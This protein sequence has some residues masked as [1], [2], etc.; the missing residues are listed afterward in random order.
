[1]AL[2]LPLMILTACGEPP[3]NDPY[4]AA[5]RGQNIRYSAFSERPKHLDPARSYSSNEVEFIGQI[6]EPPLQY[7]YLKRPYQLIPLT[8]VEVPQPRYYDAQGRRL[9]ADAPAARIA[10]SIYEIRIRP[11][12]HYQPHPAFARDAA[13]R[14]IYDPIPPK[15]LARVDK[16]SDFPVTGTRELTAEDY[17]YQ[18][19][20]LAHPRLNSPIY[21]LMSEYIVGLREFAAE[22][23]RRLKQASP[24]SWLDLRTIPLAGAEVVD[25]YTYRIRIRGKYPQFAYWL[26][27]PFFAPVPWE[28][29]RFYAQPGMQEKNLVLD[30]FPVGTGPYMLTVNDPNRQMVLERNPNFHGETYPTE[31][32]PGDREAGLLRDAGKPLP[33]IDKAVYS[34]EKEDIPYWNK[35]LQGYYDSSGISS[36]TFDQAIRIGATGDAALTEALQRKNIRLVTTVMTTI[37]Y[38]GFNMQDPVVGGLGERARKLRQAI[39]IAVDM[40]ERISIFNNGRGIPA[41]GPIPP[42][43]FGYREGRAG[44]NPYVYDWVNGHAQRKSIAEARRL[45]AEAGYPNG[46]DAQTGRP[47]VLYFDTAAVGADSKSRLEWLVKQFRKLDIELV[48]RATDYN[49]FQDKMLKGTA[50]IF[51]WGWNADYPDPENFLFLLYGPNRKVGANGENAANYENPEFDR[52]FEQ[53]KNMDNGPQRQ[54]IIDQMVEIVRR[55]AP[56]VWGFYPKAFGLYH[57]WL[58]NAKPNLMANNGLKYLRLDPALRERSRREWNQPVLWPVWTGFALLVAGLVPAAVSYWRREHRPPKKG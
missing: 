34:L 44:I 21:G 58:M 51:E 3:W 35:F 27:M 17:V 40:E 57:A 24:E 45:L 47:L 22:L 2:L 41:H 25:R 54:A 13:G 55:D 33:F 23:D 29:D 48:I 38:L 8:A 20:R 7:H 19:K 50:Q 36:D 18:L 11:G 43:I 15:L 42:G 14:L 52:L 6:Y 28:A 53:M 46:R 56:W 30:W 39:S 1:M 9:P 49:R 4:P 16:P 10:Y 32:E 31:G 5:E 37:G 12:I 26:A